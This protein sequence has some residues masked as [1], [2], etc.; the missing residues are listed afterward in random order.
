[1]DLNLILTKLAELA[2]SMGSVGIF[3]FLIVEYGGIPIPSELILP[4]FGISAAEGKTSLMGIIII[5]ILGALIGAIIC[6]Y[7]GY[8]GGTTFLNWLRRKIP[9]MNKHLDVMEK[10]FKKYGKESILI[11]RLV[12]FVRTY[13]SLL[14]GAE[15]QSMPIFIIYS[16]I[17]IAIWNIFLI[18]LGYFVGNN[19]NLIQSIITQYTYAVVAICV[20]GVLI[21]GYMKISKNKS[22]GKHARK[23]R[24]K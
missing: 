12:P 14:G 6:Y 7:I 13:I 18:L 4:F 19:M 1:M 23:R 11:L 21:Y 20:I 5:S 10:W 22:G 8:F 24:K 15:R 2:V 16:T 9:S 3:L 17:G